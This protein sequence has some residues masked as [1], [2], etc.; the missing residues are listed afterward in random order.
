[1]GLAGRV[2]RVSENRHKP[3]VVRVFLAVPAESAPDASSSSTR[4]A[5]SARVRRRCCTGRAP[6]ATSQR[7]R[8]VTMPQRHRLYD[9]PMTSPAAP[10]G[11]AGRATGDLRS[12]R[13][14]LGYFAAATGSRGLASLQSVF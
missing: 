5:W 4:C 9:A 10:G 6:T 14:I 12:G 3:Y 8:I 7:E 2:V 11:G 1:V 13:R